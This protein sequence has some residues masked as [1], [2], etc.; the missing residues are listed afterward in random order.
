MLTVHW[1]LALLIGL[2]IQGVLLLLLLVLR[3]TPVVLRLWV[4][5]LLLIL[6]RKVHSLSVDVILLSLLIGIL[7]RRIAIYLV[8]HDLG[9][10]LLLVLVAI[11]IGIESLLLLG[12]IHSSLSLLGIGDSWLH[13]IGLKFFELSFPCLLFLKLFPELLLFDLVLKHSFVPLLLQRVVL[14]Y[15]A[16]CQL[17]V[18]DHIAIHLAHRVIVS[19]F[20][21]I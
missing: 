1:R 19:L 6:I 7:L 4:L 18:I 20:C 9:L 2:T 13:I 16:A 8:L 12:F 10:L 17:R 14:A 11:L 5:V 3:T 21:V 15:L